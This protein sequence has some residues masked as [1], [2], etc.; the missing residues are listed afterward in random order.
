MSFW[1]PLVHNGA[2]VFGLRDSRQLYL[3]MGKLGP[4]DDAPGTITDIFKS[5]QLF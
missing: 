2:R 4:L 1:L 3:E 5:R